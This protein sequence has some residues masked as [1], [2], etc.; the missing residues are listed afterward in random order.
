MPRRLAITAPYEVEVKHYEDPPLKPTQVL[1]RTDLA[2]G[3]H[4]T[5]TAM[6]DG[7][8]FR[9]QVFEPEM[10]FFR[11][12]PDYVRPPPGGKPTFDWQPGTSGVGTVEAVGSQVEK[13]KPGDRVF[14]HM[15][16]RETS[17]F[18]VDYS[19]PGQKPKYKKWKKGKKKGKS[20]EGEGDVNLEADS[21]AADV[22]VGD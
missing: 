4:G 1:V 13:W 7:V 6:F 3:K 22:D 9:G 20:A 19:K 11:E 14:G 2:S 5:T 12:D 18:W 21:D 17:A 8:N 15:D 16:V 10:R